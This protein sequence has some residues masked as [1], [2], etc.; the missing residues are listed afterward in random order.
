MGDDFEE[1]NWPVLNEEIKRCAVLAGTTIYA[2]NSREGIKYRQTTD[3][4]IFFTQKEIE[5]QLEDGVYRIR[6][7]KG[8]WEWF[9]VD[10]DNLYDISLRSRKQPSSVKV[11]NQSDAMND[12]WTTSAKKMA[13]QIDQEMLD[14]LTTKYKQGDTIAG[15]GYSGGSPAPYPKTSAYEDIL[16]QYGD[17]ITPYAITK[18]INRR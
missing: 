1:M 8:D 4:D 16:K 13:N 18:K 17:A 7:N 9:E 6:L 2:Y 5:P 14:M 11:P 15:Y 3:H 10:V 12:M